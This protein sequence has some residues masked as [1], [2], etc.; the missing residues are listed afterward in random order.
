MK[1]RFKPTD[2]DKHLGLDPTTDDEPID[3]TLIE[4]PIYD[5]LDNPKDHPKPIPEVKYGGK[6]EGRE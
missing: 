3:S 1:K 4:E 6:H 2:W 5:P